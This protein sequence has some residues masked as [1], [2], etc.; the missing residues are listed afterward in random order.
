MGERAVEEESLT[1]GYI[2]KRDEFLPVGRNFFPVLLRG[3]GGGAGPGL[4]APVTLFL[5]YCRF[6][7][8]YMLT[9]CRLHEGYMLTYCRLH[10]GYMLTYCRFH[11]GYMLTYCRFHEDLLQTVLPPLARTRRSRNGKKSPRTGRNSSRFPM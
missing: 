9:Y 7:E 3:G 2:A 6:H 1:K 11:E 4:C 8:G 5:T 10:E